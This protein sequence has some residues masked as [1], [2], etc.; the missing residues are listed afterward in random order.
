MQNRKEDKLVI[1]QDC[2]SYDLSFAL[3]AD[4]L[5]FLFSSALWTAYYFNYSLSKLA[6][7]VPPEHLFSTLLLDLD[8]PGGHLFQPG[9]FSLMHWLS[10]GQ[11]DI[12]PRD[13][14]LCPL[15]LIIGNSKRL[16]QNLDRVSNRNFFCL[17]GLQLLG[18]Y[19]RFLGRLR[20]SLLYL[21]SE[22][23]HFFLNQWSEIQLIQ[24]TPL[25][26]ISFET[27]DHLFKGSSLAD[28]S[29]V[30][31]TLWIKKVSASEKQIKSVN[32]LISERGIA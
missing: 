29:N 4:N 13:H 9:S 26:Y 27:V 18:R 10:F 32:S 2:L 19:L 15:D 14:L 6:T 16:V 21:L 23:V 12:R 30:P 7:I 25:I 3:R 31:D 1:H 11:K 24:A 20:I 17:Q 8:T 28:S 22:T 5:F